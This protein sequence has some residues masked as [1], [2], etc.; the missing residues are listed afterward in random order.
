MS[1]GVTFSNRTSTTAMVILAATMFVTGF[2]GFVFE[3]ILSTVATYVLGNSVEQFSITIGLMLACM[4]LGSFAQQYVKAKRP[5]LPFVGV[6]LLLVTLGGFAPVAM[7]A[8]FGF[9]EHHFQLIQYAIAGAIGFL[10]GSEIPF[11]TRIN[12]DVRGVA[13]PNNLAAIFLWDYLG[14]FIGAVIF[15]KFLMPRMPLTEMSFLL[16]AAMLL[17]AL[18]NYVYFMD[19][20]RLAHYAVFLI[21]AS[22]LAYGYSQNRRWNVALE[23]RLYADRIIYATTT[24]YQRI[25]LQHNDTKNEY[26]LT[27]NGGLQFS[28]LDEA[29]YHEFLV[30]VPMVFARERVKVLVLGGGDGLGLREIL[31]YPNVE[32]VTL[33]DLDPAMTTFAA[34]NPVMTA[35]NHRSF[36]DARV[37]VVRSGGIAEGPRRLVSG[38]ELHPHARHLQPGE[39]PVAEVSVINIDADRFLREV[40]EIYDVVI[41][42]FPDPRSIE[43]CKLYSKEFYLK[44]RRVLSTHGVAAI[45]STSVYYSREAY[46]MIGRTLEEAGFSVL[47][48]H[49]DVPS[50]GDWGWHLVWKDERTVAQLKHDLQS[51][52]SLEVQTEYLTPELVAMSTDFGKGELRAA[53]HHINTLMEPRLLDVYLKSWVVD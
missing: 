4:G 38:E 21:V 45:Q 43:L 18:L 1:S 40:H 16:G 8:A 27:L 3:C 35:L 24:P 49:H 44:L 13:L 39:V 30:H 25:V 17:I 48:Y 51:V 41:V 47:R 20:K 12:E 15:T 46:L 11:A 28:S 14:G 19:A 42:D 22:A 6:E 34:T 29:R 2:T 23:Q 9:F 36:A 53:D 10:I 37:A 33:V 5:V 31:K 52:R 26:R 50:F 7:Y 32:S